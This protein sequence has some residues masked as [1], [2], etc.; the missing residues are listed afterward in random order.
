MNMAEEERN[1]QEHQAL[2][3]GIQQDS[4]QLELLISGFV[5][6][7][8]IGGL[9]P[10]VRWEL[11]VN[12]LMTESLV[13]VA[14]YVIFQTM[15]T[16]YVAL[17]TSLLLHVLLRG[18][19]IAAIGLRY[20][21]GDIDYARLNYRPRYTHWLK[22]RVG[23]FDEY[24]ERLEHYC[25]VIFSIAFLVIFCFLSLTT[26]II[27]ATSLQ[28][29]ARVLSGGGTG[30]EGMESTWREISWGWP[31]QSLGLFTSSILFPWGS[32]SGAS[33]RI[34]GIIPFTGSWDGQPFPAFTAHF[35]TT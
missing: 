4:W 17:L 12:M 31:P 18:L 23:S 27:F 8:L 13:Y 20:V 14:L 15:Q 28:V 21:S 22:K 5:I 25:S 33:G 6:F 11:E 26:F 34:V 2:L 16:A 10:M 29:G 7:L 35:I 32:L 19:W 1:P 9:E 3:D 24:I 30:T